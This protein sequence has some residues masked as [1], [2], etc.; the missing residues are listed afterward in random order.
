MK[1]KG[2]L[3]FASVAKTY[4]PCFDSTNASFSENGQNSIQPQQQTLRRDLSINGN[5]FTKKDVC[6]S[7]L[8]MIAAGGI[9]TL[10]FIT[11]V[12]VLI[13][14]RRSSIHKFY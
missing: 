2:P 7:P 3:H 9:L 5:P 10:L 1:K 14:A 8:I 12:V 4:F 13:K 6:L 11:V